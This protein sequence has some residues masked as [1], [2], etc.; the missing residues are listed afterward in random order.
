MLIG[1]SLKFYISLKI[2]LCLFLSC[3]TVMLSINTEEE[4]QI[5]VGQGI[6]EG[7]GSGVA[8]TEACLLQAHFSD[9]AY[10]KQKLNQKSFYSA[11]TSS[12]FVRARLCLFCKKI[13]P[14]F[15]TSDFFMG[16]FAV[17]HIFLVLRMQITRRSEKK[18][19]SI[20]EK[21]EMVNLRNS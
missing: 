10:Y 8:F 18:I 11:C 21:T 9:I 17:S 5:R 20:K 3:F 2:D 6:P 12:A 13:L 14:S 15:L 19:L 7:E 16:M 1:L 4:V